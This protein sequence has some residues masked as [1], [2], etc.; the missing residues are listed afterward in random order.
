MAIKASPLCISTNGAAETA[1]TFARGEDGDAYG[2][3]LLARL[4][5]GARDRGQFDAVLIDEAQDWPCSWFQ[6]A[7][8]ALKEPE[9]GDLLI[10]GDGS[11]ALY[12][13]RPFSWADAG[14]DARGRTI[15]TKFDLDR[16]Y[17]NTVE[18]LR[19]AQPFSAKPKRGQAGEGAGILALPVDPGKAIRNGPEPVI[20]ELETARDE[21]HYAA[22]LIETWL[23]GGVEIRGRREP[24]APRDIGIL[25]PRVRNDA[26]ELL[27]GAPECF[28]PR[29]P[30][31]ARRKGNRHPPG[32]RGAHTDHQGRRGLQ[33]RF[34]VLLWA[35]LL[36]YEQQTDERSELYVAMTRA[37]DVLVILHSGHSAYIDELR[38]NDGSNP[39]R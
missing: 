14:I 16:N 39:A 23:R 3:R 27:C 38:A 2:E 33:F 12:G 30:A 17:R 8:L 19:A 15:N 13:A 31:D 21:C 4:Q 7:K 1:P 35:D 18:I 24:V 26:M 36:P 29:G 6:C 9:T 37:E 10:V 20:V 22:A 28:H 25:Y 32:R 5:D 34:V 11:Q